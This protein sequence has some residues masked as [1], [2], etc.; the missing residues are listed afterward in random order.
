MLV[1]EADAACLIDELLPDDWPGQR[2][3]PALGTGAEPFDQVKGA[4]D[5]GL[6]GSSNSQFGVDRG[7]IFWL[8]NAT[9][10]SKLGIPF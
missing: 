2:I 10:L 5:S 4:S 6:N 7:M 3:G 1:F 9:S 8:S